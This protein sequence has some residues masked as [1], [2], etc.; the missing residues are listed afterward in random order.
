MRYRYRHFATLVSSLLL[1]V[2]TS[3]IA[4]AVDLALADGA[5]RIQQGMPEGW[6]IVERQDGQIPW[7]HHWC[8]DYRG[9]RGIKLIAV[10]P[11]IV[12]AQM[13]DRATGQWTSQPLA[14]E[15]VEIWV[16][17][18]AYRDSATAALCLHRPIQ[19]ESISRTYE[20]AVWARPA[21]RMNS[22]V[23][24]DAA[25]AQSSASGWPESPWNDWSKLSWTTW[26]QD[27]AKA[28]NGNRTSR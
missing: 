3:V 14:R 27:L 9:P 8:D 1:G 26:R 21:H 28:L 25:L 19:P 12:N 2:S 20:V 16:M 10:G 23:E 11:R 24:F 17:P 18:A 5:Q 15:A 4:L 13:R 22:T 6:R 7:G